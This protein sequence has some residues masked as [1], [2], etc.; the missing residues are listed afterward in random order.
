MEPTLTFEE[1]DKAVRAAPPRT[2]DDVSVTMDGRRLDTKE[3]VLAFLAEVEADRPVDR[4]VV[5]QLA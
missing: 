4:A 1:L 3:K 2:S 5:D